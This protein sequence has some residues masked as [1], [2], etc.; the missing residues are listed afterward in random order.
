MYG[1]GG[2]DGLFA[3]QGNEYDNFDGG[4][5]SDRLYFFNN[6]YAATHYASGEDAGFSVIH[7]GA[8]ENDS[9]TWTA[10]YWTA[11]ELTNLDDVLLVMHEHKGSDMSIQKAG[12]GPVAWVRIGAFTPKGSDNPPAWNGSGVITMN[13]GAFTSLRRFGRMVVHELGHNWDREGPSWQTFLSQSGWMQIV[14]PIDWIWAAEK[15]A[16][17]WVMTERYNETW[18]YDPTA[19]F[20]NDAGG[21]AYGRTHPCEDWATCWE[22]YFY[23]DPTSTSAVPDPFNMWMQSNMYSKCSLVHQVLG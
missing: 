22:G 1:Q 19:L 10:G 15:I 23:G 5:D 12:G 8:G 4:P 7:G 9:G 21:N 17:G 2:M 14:S 6:M 18:I 13:D 11:E 20:Y 3:Y 16:D